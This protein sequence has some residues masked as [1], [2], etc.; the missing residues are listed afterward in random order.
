[1]AST[2]SALG[3]AIRRRLQNSDAEPEHLDRLE[4]EALLDRTNEAVTSSRQVEKKRSTLRGPRPTHRSPLEQTNRVV[5]AAKQLLHSRCKEETLP[6]VSVVL[7][8]MH[9]RK[10]P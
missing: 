10:P 9:S 3:S 1:M 4:I 8:T 5:G 6:R 7:A 2:R